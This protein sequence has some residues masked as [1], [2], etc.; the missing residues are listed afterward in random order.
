MRESD[1]QSYL[2]G[3]IQELIPGSI[4]LITDPVQTPG[5]PDL[6]VLGPHAG[7]AVL[8]VKRSKSA[9]KRPNQDWY[10]NEWGKIAFSAFIYPENESEIL[11]ALQQALR[12]KGPTLIPQR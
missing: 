8:E 10:V 1:Y 4:V 2:I 5:I 9:R 3:Q 12:P 7:W 6:L 11:Y